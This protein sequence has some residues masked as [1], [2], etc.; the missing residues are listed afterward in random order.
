LGADVL[1]MLKDWLVHHIQREDQRSLA[2]LARSPRGRVLA[3]NTC[4]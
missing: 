2:G 4:V 1:Q 3:G